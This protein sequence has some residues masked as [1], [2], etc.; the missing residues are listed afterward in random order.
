MISTSGVEPLL[1]ALIQEQSRTREG[2]GASTQESC[3]AMV[4]QG[5]RKGTDVSPRAGS[6]GKEG[7]SECV[8]QLT[9]QQGKGIKCKHA[10]ESPEGA[11]TR[12]SH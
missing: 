11:K 6:T 1:D 7:R 9:Q 12:R 2:T 3:R 10:E 5:R 4:A 8:K